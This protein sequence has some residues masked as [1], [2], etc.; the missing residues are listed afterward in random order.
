MQIYAAGVNGYRM[1]PI[2]KNQKQHKQYVY[3]KKNMNPSYTAD[4]N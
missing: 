4:Q 3:I 1:N 2:W